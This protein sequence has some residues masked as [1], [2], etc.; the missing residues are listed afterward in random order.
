MDK[1]W[2][3]LGGIAVIAFLNV[4]GMYALSAIILLIV[5]GYY[6]MESKS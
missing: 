1:S 2:V 5:G 4:A 3:L 6:A